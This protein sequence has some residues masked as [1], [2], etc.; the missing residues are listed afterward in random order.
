MKTIEL[1][2]KKK[3]GTSLH[4]LTFTKNESLKI[5][6]QTPGQ[7]LNLEN[8]SGEQSFFAIASAPEDETI[9]ILVKEQ[10]KGIAYTLSYM[11][12][13]TEVMTSEAMGKGFSVQDVVGKDLH[14]FSMGSGAAPFRA[15]IRQN[16]KT[17]Y[18]AK[19]ITLWQGSRFI[20]DLP[21]VN[22]YNSWEESKMKIHRCLSQEDNLKNICQLLNSSRSSLKN[23]LG[24]WIGSSD[25][26]KDLVEVLEK[27]NFPLD[28]LSSN[29]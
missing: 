27:K 26:K 18:N 15:L 1:I 25:F 17:P 11:E 19:S 6:Y 28:K 20:R 13:G 10:S 8:E 9:D 7:Y 12:S 5:T 21:F 3:Y 23:A 14:L 29:Y 2:S 22:E 16:H 4:H 24:F